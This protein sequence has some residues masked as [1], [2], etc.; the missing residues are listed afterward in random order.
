[1]GTPG[2]EPVV[3]QFIP[4]CFFR[5]ELPRPLLYVVPNAVSPIPP[6]RVIGRRRSMVRRLAEDRSEFATRI[7]FPCCLLRSGPLIAVDHF[8]IERNAAIFPVIFK[9]PKDLVAGIGPAGQ[10]RHEVQ[11]AT[12]AQ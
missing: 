4:I 2:G 7:A 8:G 12:A 9:Y 1:M 10:T 6:L 11:L 5:D 3:F